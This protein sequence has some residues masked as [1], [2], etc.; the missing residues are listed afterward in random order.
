[1]DPDDPQPRGHSDGLGVPAA[2]FRALLPVA[3]RLEVLED[4][5]AEHQ[6]RVARQG[7]LRARLWL[8]SQLFG[9]MPLL[10]AR[11]WWRGWTGFEP[12]SSRL[13]PGGLVLESWIMDMR[14][15]ARRLTSR[16]LYT[17]LAVLTLALGAGGTAAIFSIVRA[18]LLNPLPVAHE[19][20]LGVLWFDGSW[21][22][23]EFLHFRPDFPGFSRMAAYMSGD[24]TLDIPGQPLQLVHGIDTSAELFDVAGRRST[25]R[26]RLPAWRR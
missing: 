18:L 26:S 9:S 20:Q 6:T 8:W 23:Q 11:A 24:Q 1:M 14:Y 22:E 3:E 17:C 19:E 25:D 15:S 16:P 5:A 21:T 12:R 2:L 4:L 10:V 7:H 13:Q